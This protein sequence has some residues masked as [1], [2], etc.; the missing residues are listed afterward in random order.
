MQSGGFGVQA[1]ESMRTRTGHVVGQSQIM[2]KQVLLLV[3]VS[4]LVSRLKHPLEWKGQGHASQ[5]WTLSLSL[6]PGLEFLGAPAASPSARPQQRFR[7]EQ[8]GN[9]QQSMEKKV[10]DLSRKLQQVCQL[11]CA[12]DQTLRELEAWSTRTYILSADTELRR[13]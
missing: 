3:S 11:V 1:I 9:Q 6:M 2:D 5:P 4:L 8:A 13:T 7:P 10:E 12:H